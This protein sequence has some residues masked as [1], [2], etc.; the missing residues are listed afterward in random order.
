[1][2]ARPGSRDAVQERTKY[3]PSGVRTHL[4]LR[5]QFDW[6]L[7]TRSLRLGE[8]TLLM[9]IVNITPDSFSDGGQ[10]FATKAAVEQAL[11]L[12][13]EGADLIDLGAESTRPNA[14]AITAD[15]EQRRLLPVLEALLK[16]RPAVIVSVDTYHAATARAALAA[17]AEI[18]N[19]V[20]GLLW[21]R[22]M[23]AV[24]GEAKPGVVLMH[25]RGTP[26][27]WAQLP[28]LSPAEV[29][30]LVRDGLAA[31]LALAAEAGLPREQVVLDPG[32]GFG[33][34]GSANFALLAG[35]AELRELGLPLLAGLSRKR[36]L[37]AHLT[38]PTAADRE[39]ATSAANV[40]AILGGAHLVRVHDVASARLAA[41]IA[42][43]VLEG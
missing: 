26:Q 25:T 11:R 28:L 7:R 20:S 13:D 16:A 21:D 19:D 31:S 8:R 10:F 40:A 23:A 30:P 24:L 12:L 33:K 32:F 35:F 2:V 22:D 3:R 6:K 4:P 39:A 41:A 34:I 1:M 18:I 9:G 43:A 37:T 29:L 36:F 42:D 5:P 17:G 14:A 27:Q 15:A 38:A